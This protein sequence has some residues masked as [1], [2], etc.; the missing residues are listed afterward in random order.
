LITILLALAAVLVL[1]QPAFAVSST[2]C[3]ARHASKPPRSAAASKPASVSSRA[4]RALVASFGQV[5]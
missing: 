4:A 3:K 5:Q 1:V 2:G